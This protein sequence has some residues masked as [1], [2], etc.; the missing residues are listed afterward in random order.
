MKRFVP[1]LLALCCAASLRA[2]DATASP[3]P[4]DSNDAAGAQTRAATLELA[5]AF[6]NDGYKIRDG[7]YF[8]SLEPGKPVLIEVN[9][10]AGNEYWFCA[11]GIA[12]ARKVTIRVYDEEGKFVE[13]QSYGDGASA[14][15]GVVAPWSGKF[16]VQVSLNEGEKAPFT[17]LYCYK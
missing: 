13:Q 1:L 16:F 12:P 6:S 7:F 14:A 15:A 11:A 10:F 8:G 9:L 17:F 2:Q 3:V 4:A 5:G